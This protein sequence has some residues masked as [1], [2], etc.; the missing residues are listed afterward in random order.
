MRLWK[1]PELLRNLLV[2][3]DDEY[4]VLGDNRNNSQDSRAANVGVI[5]KDDLLGRA[6]VRIWPLNKFGV[7]K[8]E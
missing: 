4:F 7:I 6:W 1:T 2:L 8:H 3:G 5:H